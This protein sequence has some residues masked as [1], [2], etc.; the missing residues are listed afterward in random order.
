MTARVLAQHRC[1]LKNGAPREL[2]ACHAGPHI[3]D[4]R[5]RS[6]PL[7]KSTP[8]RYASGEPCQ[9]G[10]MNPVST[11]AP[12]VVPGRSCGSC[13]LCCKVVGVAELSKPPGTW[14]PH[15]DRAKGCTIYETR[16]T[17]CR[18]FFCHW[19]LETGLGPDWKPER[20][21]FALLSSAAGMTV[22]VDPGYP[23]AWKQAPYYQTFKRWAVAGLNKNP[24]HIIS[25]RIGTRGIVVLPD[26]DVDLGA[27]APDETIWLGPGP[28]G[29]VDVRK[30]KRTEPH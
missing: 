18:T 7:R 16:P 6:D 20:C 26:R 17:D 3:H 10:A 30:V 22:F 2:H 23:G 11:I 12:P 29:G 28:G 8:S 19:M 5:A 4:K 25:I 15:C 24:A 9:L 27:V 1:L 13:T 14:C 21:K